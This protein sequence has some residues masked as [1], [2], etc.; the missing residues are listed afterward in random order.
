M[1]NVCIYF[2]V[3]STKIKVY[4]FCIKYCTKVAEHKMLV[5]CLARRFQVN[6]RTIF[7]LKNFLPMLRPMTHLLS[8][9][10]CLHRPAEAR[11]SC[12][13][14]PPLHWLSYLMPCSGNNFRI[15][16]RST[17]DHPLRRVSPSE[18]SKQIGRA[19]CRERV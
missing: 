6:I 14:Q 3:S 4:I 2:N 1:D 9:F 12:W 16:S 17:T 11:N 18:L 8:Y 10:L 13:K 15:E 5:S 7:D 19:S